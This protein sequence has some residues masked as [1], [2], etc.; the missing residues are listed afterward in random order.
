MMHRIWMWP[1]VVAVLALSQG[2]GQATWQGQTDG[3]MEPLVVGW[4][5]IF[6]LD[7]QSGDLRER[8]MVW[9]YIN[10]DSPYA[11]TRIQLLVDALDDAGQVVGQRVGWVTGSMG[12][13]SRRY[14]EL[15]A[16]QAAARYRVRVFAFDR[17]ESP[18][19][20]DF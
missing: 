11:V 7:W 13:F 6:K 17:L 10:N 8:P 18:G 3:R 15:P 5:Q 2:C 4:E 12:A 16:P 14:F 9:G 19:M 20:R 1:M